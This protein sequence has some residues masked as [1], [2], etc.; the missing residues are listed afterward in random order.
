MTRRC[1]WVLACLLLPSCA[2]RGPAPQLLDDLG[3]AQ[4]LVAAGCYSCLA[5]A[6]VIYERVAASPRAPVDAVKR[7]FEAALL[8]AVRSKELG[9]PEQEP[10]ARARALAARVPAPVA[11]GLTTA[12]YLAAAELTLGESSGFDPE[13]R[14][15]RARE[16]RNAYGTNITEHAARLALT[17]AVATDAVAAYLAIAIDCDDARARK[18]I[19]ADEVLRQHGTALMRYRL[20]LCALGSDALASFREADPRWRDT[21]FFEGRR[22]ITRRPIADVAAA[23]GLLAQAHETFPTSVA[24]TLGLAVARNALSEYE[25]ALTLYD[26]VLA[27]A[28]T[29]RD[30]LLGRTMSLSYLMRHPEAI[31]AASHMIDLGTWHIGDAYYWRAWNRY[32]LSELEPAWSDIERATKLNVNSGVYMLAGVIAYAR[33]DLDI[34]IARLQ[35]SYEL[36]NENCEAVWT[37]SLVHVEQQAWPLAAPRFALAVTCFTRTA[38]QARREIENFEKAAVA[39]AL[40]KQR[41][42]ATQK[43]VETAEHRLAQSAFNAASSYLRLGE[44]Y[45]ALGHVDTAAGHPLLKEKAA[46]LRATID[47]LP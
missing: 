7:A 39:E 16:R 11:P 42:A 21:L 38:A 22:E 32:Q 28:P 41:I 9:I 24:I 15:R 31:A 26:S 29:H 13:A 10:L 17:P 23:A 40:K 36:D 35:R 2:A 20:A 1:V 37:E 12:D 4:A 19:N 27:D 43:R 33:K 3:K 5:D 45:V 8:L 25:P 14:E 44:K 47:K 18:A 34:A 30:A 46:A 6:L